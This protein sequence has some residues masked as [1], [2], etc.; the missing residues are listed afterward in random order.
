MHLND[1]MTIINKTGRGHDIRKLNTVVA[2]A[3][4]GNGSIA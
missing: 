2:K 4:D 3:T 1:I